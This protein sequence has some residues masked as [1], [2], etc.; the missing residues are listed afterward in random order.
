MHGLL[1]TFTPFFMFFLM[2]YS[3]T[4]FDKKIFLTG[5]EDDVISR[6]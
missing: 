4:G 6:E 3:L 5:K 2:I 1:L